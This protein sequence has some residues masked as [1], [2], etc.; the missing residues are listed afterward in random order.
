M[1]GQMY[2]QMAFTASRGAGRYLGLKNGS[3]IERERNI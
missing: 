2:A 3:P 1:N